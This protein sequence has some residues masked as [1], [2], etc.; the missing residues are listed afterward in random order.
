MVTRNLVFGLF[1]CLASGYAPSHATFEQIRKGTHYNKVVELLGEPSKA[2]ESGDTTYLWY[3]YNF[4]SGHIRL[5]L[6]HGRVVDGYAQIY[7]EPEEVQ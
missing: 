2:D 4:R 6:T 3:F 1:L 7:D 5:T